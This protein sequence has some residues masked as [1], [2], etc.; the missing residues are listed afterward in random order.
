VLDA[1]QCAI[2]L[3]DEADPAYVRLVAIHNSARQV[4]GEAAAF[5]I[6]FQLTIQQAMRRK[7]HV[8]VDEPDNVQLKIL[9][10]LLGSGEAGPLLVYPLLSN[11]E[12]LGAIVVGNSR[13]RRAFTH[14]DVKL[15]QAMAA[16]V[17]AA[18][19]NA[20]RYQAAQD[21]IRELHRTLDEKR[22]GLQPIAQNWDPSESLEGG[23]GAEL[24]AF[25]DP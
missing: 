13:S 11:G 25:L 4:P 9:F 17:V 22:H 1:D 18:M 6:D 15:C 23:S 19:Q 12:A 10:A 8:T 3:P 20:Q 16:H 14:H 7:K 2:A 5:P 21:R 24:S